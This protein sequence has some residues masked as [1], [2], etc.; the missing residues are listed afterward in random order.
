MISSSGLLLEFSDGRAPVTTLAEVDAG[1]APYG[2]RVWRLDLADVPED[3]RLLLQ[4][5]SVTSDEADRIRAHFLLSRQRLLEIIAAA[6]RTPHVPGGGA[7]NPF[8][9]NHRYAY[10]QLYA[11]EAGVDYSRFDRFHVNTADDGTGVD[12][13]GQL[14]FGGGVR[15][16]QR[17]PAYGEASLHLACPSPEHGWIVTYDGGASHI[18]SLSGASP[19]TKFLM[20]V[21]G[22]ERWVMRY[23][24]DRIP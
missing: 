18:G 12:E 24:E 13:I 21:I 15:I 23:D 11:A 19:G 20:Q 6:G 5:P 14:L 8:V 1:L 16:I 4:Q 3:V 2:S 7:M 17:R 10:P 9:E 22:P